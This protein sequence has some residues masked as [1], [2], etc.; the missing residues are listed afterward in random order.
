[1]SRKKRLKMLKKATILIILINLLLSVLLAE[2][3]PFNSNKM[4]LDLNKTPSALFFNRGF[5]N[6]ISLSTNNDQLVSFEID[7]ALSKFYGFTYVYNKDIPNS[8]GY[9]KWES[10]LFYYKNLFIGFS[11]NMHIDKNYKYLPWLTFSFVK[12][13]PNFVFN[14]TYENIGDLKNPVEGE[15]FETQLTYFNKN[16]Q[17]QGFFKR[18]FALNKSSYGIFADI[19][20]VN[21]MNIFSS[22]DIKNNYFNFG[23]NFD[24]SNFSFITN[25]EKG[26][27]SN[28]T[29]GLLTTTHKQNNLFYSYKKLSI[30]I[31]GDYDFFSSNIVL[32][33]HSLFKLIKELNI[34]YKSKRTKLL[35]VTIKENDLSYADI[36]QIKV[37]L[38]KI[39]D[40]GTKVV[41]YLDQGIIP[42]KDYYLATGG[43][44][45]ITHPQS[46]IFMG[47]IHSTTLY[48]GSFLKLL[49]IHPQFVRPDDCIYK[50][51]IE[52]YTSKKPSEPAKQDKVEYMKDIF[53]II[54]NSIL[55]NRRL[56]KQSLDTII[57]NFPILLSSKAKK[58]NL[59]DDT[60]Y[61]DEFKEKFERKSKKVQYL[62]HTIYQLKSVAIVPMN[63]IILPKG[64]ATPLM[65][66]IIS[67]QRYKKVFNDLSKRK[68]IKAVIIYLNSPGGDSFSS[69]KLY[70]YI[71][72]MKE[73]GK[74]V[75]VYMEDLG[76]SGGYYLS[77]AADKIFTNPFT[78]TGSIG[79]FAGKFY[80]EK[81][82]NFM[83]IYE[84]TEKMGDKA[85]FFSPYTKWNDEDIKIMKMHLEKLYNIFKK[86]VS[87]GRHLDM[88]MV[89]QLAKGKI[90]SGYS[91]LDNKLC[92]RVISFNEALKDVFNDIGEKFDY[93][94]I[95]IYSGQCGF[96]NMIRSFMKTPKVLAGSNIWTLYLG[97]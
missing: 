45:I 14:M 27:D 72:K 56:E 83:R 79:I 64:M 94:R 48:Y 46:S 26:L 29:A 40:S 95:D 65:G 62:S 63:G 69:E 16:F 80:I 61:E 13:I 2:N 5:S 6:Y 60:L 67:P 68:N 10:P 87:D 70:H 28:Y 24:L 57:N 85:D 90:Y 71:S 53:T 15:N 36:Y 44:I 49:R 21:G 39:R 89:G 81:A 78:I 3:I 37:L 92:D 88:N 20:V 7:Q 35:A 84:N 93:E 52:P 47:G 41:I 50:S 12:V 43:D 8:L 11:F 76:A 91:A 22:Y 19:S 66:K 30:H 34:I 4:I 23:I 58:F 55:R 32:K 77:A 42:F 38:E 74:K 51:A 31:A 86:R 25:Y 54:K 97:D 9:L 73:R 59:I 33:K 17:L 96:L 82:Y 18:V 1:M 75:Y